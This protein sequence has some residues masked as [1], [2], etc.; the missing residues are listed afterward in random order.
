MTFLKCYVICFCFFLASWNRFP[1]KEITWFISLHLLLVWNL[2]DWLNIG[3]E[4][5]IHLSYAQ[6]QSTKV[7]WGNHRQY[8]CILI[9]L[10]NRFWVLNIF[11]W[12]LMRT[13][14]NNI[15]CTLLESVSPT[16]SKIN[17][18]LDLFNPSDSCLLGALEVKVLTCL[19]VSPFWHS[20]TAGVRN[21]DV[22]WTKFYSL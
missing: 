16:N 15:S 9:H 1:P 8:F 10:T 3:N 14:T 6:E 12:Q 2:T 5:V 11:F 22:L 17:F 7:G 18:S 20:D 13:I 19:L 21:R 4:Y